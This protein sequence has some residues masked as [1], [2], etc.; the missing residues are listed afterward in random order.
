MGLLAQLLTL[1]VEYDRDVKPAW[2][3]STQ[4]T[5]N[6]L[7]LRRHVQQIRTTHHV[8]D[9]LINVI[10]HHRHLIGVEPLLAEDD[11]IVKLCLH[12]LVLGSQQLVLPV[13][14]FVFEGKADCEW[15]VTVD[16]CASAALVRVAPLIGLQFLARA[17][18]TIRVAAF[19]QPVNGVLIG[20]VTSGLKAYRLVGKQPVGVKAGND[21]A[22]RLRRLSQRIQV[23]NADKPLAALAAGFQKAGKCGNE[24]AKVQRACRRGRKPAPVVRVVHGGQSAGGAGK[25]PNRQLLR[26]RLRCRSGVRESRPV[27]CSRCTGWLL[28]EL[29]DGGYRFPRHTDRRSHSRLC[30]CGRWSGQSS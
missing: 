30:R 18:A 21:L 1:R 12:R 20:V 13:A 27:S 25:S 15:P 5:I 3:K 8:R 7:L 17:L 19:K 9:A 11:R 23:F 26:S 29:P 2:R 10:D 4:G 28:V 6:L 24:G 22:G 14:V 16:F